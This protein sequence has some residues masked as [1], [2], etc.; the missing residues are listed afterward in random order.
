[1]K[2]ELTTMSLKDWKTV[3]KHSNDPIKKFEAG[4]NTYLGTFGIFVKIEG[5]DVYWMNHETKEWKPFL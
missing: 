3:F 1:M 4:G 2:Q 5:T